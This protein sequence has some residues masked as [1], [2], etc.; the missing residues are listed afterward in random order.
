MNK[1]TKIAAS[2][3]SILLIINMVA[4]AGIYVELSSVKTEVDEVKQER[5]QLN[6]Y[7]LEQGDFA[8][9]NT[10]STDRNALQGDILAHTSSGSGKAVEFTY[11]PLPTNKIYIDTSEA[12]AGGQFQSS[13]R[14]AQETIEE[15]KYEPVGDGMAVSLD[16]PKNWDFFKGGSAGLAFAA[17]IAST[18]PDYKLRDGVTFTGEVSERGG[19]LTV[20]NIE[21]KARAAER[22][23]YEVILT[24]YNSEE[25]DVE[26]IEVVEVQSVEEALSYALINTEEN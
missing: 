13:L 25:I 23:G 16:T 17:H 1:I 14:K 9:E 7:L 19:V 4:T 5:S 21:E 3:F 18:D 15:S 12:T 11:Q 24:P 2:V 10:S 8:T 22:N 6:D 20:Q 26:G